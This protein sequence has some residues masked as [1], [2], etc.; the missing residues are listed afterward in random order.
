[1]NPIKLHYNLC[2]TDLCNIEK[3]YNRSTSYSLFYDGIFRDKQK[4]TLN[5]AIVG[6]PVMWRDYFSESNIYVHNPDEQIV[7]SHDY[8]YKTLRELNVHY[9][10]IIGN[11]TR[12]DPLTIIDS[13]YTFLK[14]DG[15]LFIE[16]EVDMQSL[17]PVLHQF[18]KHYRLELNSINS[19]GDPLLILTK[20]ELC[21]NKVTIITPSYRID[22]LL[23]IRKSIQLDYVDEWIIVYDG[24]K[25]T[26]NPHLF[27]E[28]QIKEFVHSG[29]G[30]EGNAQ[31]NYGLSQVKNP[32][33][34]LYFLDD[35]NLVHLDL[36]TLLDVI[37]PQKMYTFNQLNR[38][39]GNKIEISCID[40]AMAIMPFPSCKQIE[41]RLDIIASDGYYLMDCYQ[42]NI[43][44]HVYVDNDLCYH[45]KINPG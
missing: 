21:K 24:S 28:D 30:I 13:V 2:I 44:D 12:I 36:Y 26:E 41:W 1:M 34:L 31:R 29:Y 25:I 4:K 5:I 43:F 19:T 15:L 14:P 17:Q 18:K 3:K 37:D 11:D 9:D 8:L 22:N 27:H 7:R 33:T 16:N 38:L 10:I 45:N 39:S 40:T 23:K 35:D 42:A 20:G 32:N 6:D